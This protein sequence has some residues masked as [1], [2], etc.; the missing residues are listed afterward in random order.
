MCLGLPGKILEIDGLLAQVDFF[1]VTKEVRLDIVDE[2][3]SIGDYIL[4]HVGFA[5]RRIPE[6]EVEETL[7]LFEE[8]MGAVDAEE[9]MLVDIGQYHKTSKEGESDGGG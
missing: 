4:N 7:T 8:M 9:L 1:G 2:P 6:E 3:V 5:I